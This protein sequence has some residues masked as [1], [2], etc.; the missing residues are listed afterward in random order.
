MVLSPIFY[1][2]FTT[3]IFLQMVDDL[4]ILD[5]IQI[6]LP[7]YALQALILVNPP[8]FLHLLSYFIH[9]L[10]FVFCFF[11]LAFLFSFFLISSIFLSSLQFFFI[12]SSHLTLCSVNHS[13]SHS[14]FPFCPFFSYPFC[15]PHTVYENSE[16]P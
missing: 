15:F 1:I 13:L 9:L 16:K 6:S 2:C 11:L 7:I 14:F 4:C 5:F 10:L 8:L 12:L 3:L